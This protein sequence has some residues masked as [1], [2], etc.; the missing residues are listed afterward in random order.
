MTA[1]THQ[2][3]PARGAESEG[4]QAAP[5][6]WDPASWQQC[7]KAQHDYHGQKCCQVSST[8]PRSPTV[9]YSTTGI[10]P[11]PAGTIFF[12]SSYPRQHSK[13]SFQAYSVSGQCLQ[14]PGGTW[15]QGMWTHAG[16]SG[17]H[18]GRQP[19]YSLLWESL[20][21]CIVPRTHAACTE[22]SSN[23]VSD[24]RAPGAALLGHLSV[25]STYWATHR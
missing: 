20:S 13:I 7:L 22:G 6:P 8:M 11:S 4:P 24:G 23:E 1:Y 5:L 15:S 17:L 9:E 16:P 10:H 19:R 18:S 12:G 3:L 21:Q 25:L 14:K 2:L